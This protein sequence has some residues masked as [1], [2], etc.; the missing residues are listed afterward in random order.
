MLS[1]DAA[2]LKPLVDGCNLLFAN[3]PAAFANARTFLALEQ[4]IRALVI[5]FARCA[6][7]C[8]LRAWLATVKPMSLARRCPRLATMR[9]KGRRAA[10]LASSF[11]PIRVETSYFAVDHTRKPGTK[12]TKR[13]AACGQGF[14]ALDVL[15]ITDH[16]T[17]CLREM[18]ARELLM[19][20]SVKDAQRSLLA[21]GLALDSKRLWAITYGVGSELVAYQDRL[22]SGKIPFPFC[23][24]GKRIVLSLDGGRVRTR[25]PTTMGR[26]RKNGHRGFATPW[27][28]PKCFLLYEL[29]VHG[30]RD[31]KGLQ[32]SEGSLDNA[33]ETFALLERYLKAMQIHKASQILVVNDG[34]D[35]IW[36]GL[37]DLL[38][39]DILP[40]NKTLQLIDFYHATEYVT[41]ICQLLG[42]SS[43]QRGE[44]F[45]QVKAGG[46]VACLKSFKTRAVKLK[47]P[48]RIAFRKALAYLEKRVARLDYGAAQKKN[49]PLG[50]G[51]MESLIRRVV[52]L[53]LKGNSIFWKPENAEHMLALRTYF[54]VGRWAEVV[55]QVIAPLS[56]FQA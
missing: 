32:I 1:V 34:A 51:A 12:R 11:G 42:A 53:R 23:A 9:C 37:D 44:Y 24:Q 52:N 3:L 56:P 15:G 43:K 27:R 25:V 14:P 7:E 30:K 10:T 35:W 50:S 31:P 46:I 38:D 4:K 2:I 55:Q 5:D 6:L 45:T 39:R 18:V 40:Q 49:L 29:D 28:E 21:Q 20:G 13:A 17:P 48:K 36:N 22:S 33:S 8:F 19:H 47:G 54:K 16:A 26:R 41:K